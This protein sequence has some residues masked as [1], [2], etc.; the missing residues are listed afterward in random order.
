M[1]GMKPTT[2]PVGIWIRRKQFLMIMVY[3]ALDGWHHKA[4]TGSGSDNH[5][6]PLFPLLILRVGPIGRRCTKELKPSS[7]CRRMLKQ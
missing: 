2:L 6:A 5:F 1:T 7:S 3:S 4:G